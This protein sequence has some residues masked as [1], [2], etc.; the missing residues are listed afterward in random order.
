MSI[1][2]DSPGVL[3]TLRAKAGR[4]PARSC[5]P[6]R[7]GGGADHSGTAAPAAGQPCPGTGITA[8]PRLAGAG[9]H[10]SPEERC[11]EPAGRRW[12][13]RGCELGGAGRDHAVLGSSAAATD[14]MANRGM[15]AATPE[16]AHA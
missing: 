16:A 2:G 13:G 8:E 11:L 15:F 6:G 12:L 14:V 1:F 7:G 3:P 9:H 4:G 10:S 5:A